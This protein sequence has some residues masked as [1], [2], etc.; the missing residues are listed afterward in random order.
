MAYNPDVAAMHYKKDKE[1]RT[2]ADE[3]GEIWTYGDSWAM[4]VK[5]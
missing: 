3:D 4:V 5:L 2:K 1:R